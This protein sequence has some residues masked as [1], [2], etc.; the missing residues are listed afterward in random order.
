[1]GHIQKASARLE[2]LT[3]EILFLLELAAGKITPQKNSV[4]LKALAEKVLRGFPP[5]LKNRIDLLVDGSEK[6]V[7]DPDLLA[8]AFSELI[9][10]A[11]KFSAPDS[12]IEISFSSAGAPPS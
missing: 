5:E 3:A 8:K 2:K 10:N 4:V 11:G 6:L 1:M 12:K 9:E 7:V